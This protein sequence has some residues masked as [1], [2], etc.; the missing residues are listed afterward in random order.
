MKSILQLLNRSPRQIS[1]EKK[2][3]LLIGQMLVAYQ[4]NS[5]MTEAIDRLEQSLKKQLNVS[6]NKVREEFSYTLDAAILSLRGWLLAF[7]ALALL[8]LM[9]SFNR[10]F[11][12][13][14]SFDEILTYNAEGVESVEEA[15][16]NP[17]T[18]S[19]EQE[20]GR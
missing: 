18:L 3:D 11:Q 6:P 12:S 19:S 2:Q 14:A 20:Y 8:L 1:Y 9:L 4:Q 17:F 10:N 7:S 15:S 16:P 13:Q 5:Q